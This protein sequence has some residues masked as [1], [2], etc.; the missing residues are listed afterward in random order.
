VDEHALLGDAEAALNIARTAGPGSVQR[1]GHALVAQQRADA[2]VAQDLRKALSRNGLSLHYQPIIDLQDFTVR[3]FEA[4]LRWQRGGDVPTRPD[5]VL[6]TAHREG[7][8]D[9][10]VSWVLRTATQQMAEWK[11]Q[12][13]ATSVW[14]NITPEAASAGFFQKAVRQALDRTAL[15]SERLCLEITEE[16]LATPPE[17]LVPAIEALRAMG[18]QV[19]VDDFGAGYSS[20]SRLRHLPV[21][22]LKIDRS[23]LSRLPADPIDIS[24]IKAVVDLG[25]ARAL[26]VVAEG[27]ETEAQLKAVQQVGC[28][29]VQGFL[30]SPAMAADEVVAWARA[31]HA[32]AAGLTAITRA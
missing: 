16:A 17:G 19:A 21:D 29:C 31:Q 6:R 1:Y 28:H 32:K 12:G 2:R 15:P 9:E 3:G 18:V 11:A 7:L 20:L 25:N 27:V 26:R 5:V 10:L 8:S 24:I 23:F 4:L 13:L 30:F 14:L 22:V